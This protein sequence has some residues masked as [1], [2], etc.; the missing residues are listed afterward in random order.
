MPNI[1]KSNALLILFFILLS[2][3]SSGC[4]SN[5]IAS[6]TNSE[7][8]K[9][10]IIIENGAEYTKDCTPI[11]AIF[12]EG[13]AYMSFSGDGESW[14]EWIDYDTYYD[15][16]NIANGFMVPSLAQEQDISLFVLKTRMMIYPL[17]MNLP[18][19]PLNMRWENY[20]LSRF[21]PKK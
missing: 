14:T 17:R 19:I 8:I 9:G 13:A 18:L 5:F 11:F 10:S 16:F 12:S 2:I 1:F 7:I 15:E 6:P 3:F 4:V 20:I 21:L